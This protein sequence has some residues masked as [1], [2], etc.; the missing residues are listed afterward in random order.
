MVNGGGGGGLS[1]IFTVRPGELVLVLPAASTD[2]DAK[3]NVPFGSAVDVICQSPFPLVMPVPN[4]VLFAS[5]WIFVLFGP[6]PVNVGVLSS[7]TL[8]V[9]LTPVSDAG[10]KSGVPVVPGACVSNVTASAPDVPDVCPLSL[11]RA[12]N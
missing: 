10:V 1:W 7:V 9:L 2:R 11:A 8:S 6:L 3:T 12:L 5:S 4:T